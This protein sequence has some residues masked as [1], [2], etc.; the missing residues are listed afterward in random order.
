MSGGKQLDLAYLMDCMEEIDC[1]ICGSPESYTIYEGEAFRGGVKIRYVI[2]THC[3]HI[4]LSPRPSL[5]GYKEFY[6]HDDYSRMTLSGAGKS[7]D[8]KM[9]DYDS[10]IPFQ[11]KIE[12]GKRLY[13]EYVSGILKE[14]DIV[15]DFGAGNGG[16]LY[17]LQEL[18]KCRVDGNEASDFC[19]DFIKKRI[20]ID[21]FPGPIEEVGNQ[22][23]DKYREQARLCIVSG[24]L[25]HMVD[26]TLCLRTAHDILKEDGYLYICNRGL[27]EHYMSL[28]SKMRLFRELA[29]ID[30][31]HYFHRD[32]YYYMVEKAGFQ[33]LHFNPHSNVRYAHMDLF[34]KKVSQT[35][36]VS[37]KT[38]YQNVLA[39]IAKMEAD[40]HRYRSFPARLLRYIKRKLGIRS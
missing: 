26:P 29:T 11:K 20:G 33:V 8:E 21:I 5:Q 23:I 36:D 38:S 37:P 13:K 3:T 30:H 39:Q 22:I 2:C 15:F 25:Q 7:Y 18:S 34:A 40:I 31:P 10:D 16:W 32:A 28:Q 1:P 17:G 4:Y 9:K 24:S 12:E 35:D 19:V 27:F 6:R 14:G